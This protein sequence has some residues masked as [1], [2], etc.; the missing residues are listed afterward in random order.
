HEYDEQALVFEVRGLKTEPHRGAGVGVIF[1]GTD[2][3]VVISSYSDAA[4]FDPS[5]NLVEK[6]SGSA[7]HFDNVLKGVRSRN[8]QDLTAD[9][10]QGHYSSALCHLGNIS[11][12]LGTSATTPDVRRQLESLTS[13]D[14][15]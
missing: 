1:E 3:Y 14:H 15:L 8:H 13:S 11:Y 2:G 9:I 4:A 12:Q 6:F 10:E 5:G 7:D